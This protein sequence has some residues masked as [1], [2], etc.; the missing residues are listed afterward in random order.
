V[1]VNVYHGDLFLRSLVAWTAPFDW[2]FPDHGFIEM[3]N[4]NPNFDALLG[5]DIFNQG[6][7]V[8]NGGL[9]QAT[10]SW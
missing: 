2:K 6:V 7:L 5:M 1:P 9:K 4:S 8:V 10:F 3:V